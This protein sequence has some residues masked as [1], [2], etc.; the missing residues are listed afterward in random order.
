MNCI[1]PSSGHSSSDLMKRAFDSTG[2]L[3]S[4]DSLPPSAPKIR[5]A[6][7]DGDCDA[8]APNNSGSSNSS[9]AVGGLGASLQDKNRFMSLDI[10]KKRREIQRLRSDL[11]S[12]TATSR[13]KEADVTATHVLLSEVC[14]HFSPCDK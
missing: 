14:F 13:L 2:D 8:S 9:S 1:S 5:R 10:L 3:G 12:A 6:F 4:E 11:L 7:S